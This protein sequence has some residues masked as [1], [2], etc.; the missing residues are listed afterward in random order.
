VAPILELGDTARRI[1]AGSY[2]A[3]AEKRREDELGALTD[4]INDMS[5]KICTANQTQTEF[6][7][8]VSHELRTPLTAIAGWSETMLYDEAIQGDSRRGV[9][10]ILKESGRLTNMVEELLE[11]SRIRDGRF[12]LNFETFDIC[13]EVE[14]IVFTYGKLLGQKE[15]SWSMS[16]R[17]RISPRSPATPAD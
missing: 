7:S 3:L 12:T 8:S 16:L 15:S 1:A 14:D 11:F 4:A 13:A 2:G 17:T 5:V 9:N 10:I 6:I